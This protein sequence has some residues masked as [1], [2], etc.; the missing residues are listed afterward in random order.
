MA[1]EADEADR[2]AIDELVDPDLLADDVARAEVDLALG[3]L[4]REDE[5]LRARVVVDGG[6]RRRDRLEGK[7][8]RGGGS[9]EGGR[10]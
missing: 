6:R 2:H 1:V 9:P 3:R 5:R 7:G 8:G 4:D 10:G